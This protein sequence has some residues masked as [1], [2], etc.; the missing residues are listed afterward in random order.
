MYHFFQ[1]ITNTSG[2]SLVGYYGRVIDTTS[3][4]V[5]PIFADDAS[6]PIITVSGVTNTAKTDSVGNMSL[7]VALG[8]YH[9][10]IYGSDATTFLYRVSNVPMMSGPT[11]ATGA[12]GP[13]GSTGAT[14]PSAPGYTTIALGLAGTTEAQAFA[15]PQE[16]SNYLDVYKHVGSYAEF[17]RSDPIGNGFA[18]EQARVIASAIPATPQFLTQPDIHIV[19]NDALKNR[20][21]I[22]PNRSTG[23]TPSRNMFQLVSQISGGTITPGYGGHDF[24]VQLASGATAT[25]F[26]EYPTTADYHVRFQARSTTGAGAQTFK[27]LK[28]GSTVL[29]PYNTSEGAALDMDLTVTGAQSLA[30]YAQGV[31]ADVVGDGLV[32]NLVELAAPQV[33][34]PAS[35]ALVNSTYLSKPGQ[36]AIAH[37]ALIG[38]YTGF[39]K[40][41]ADGSTAVSISAGTFI[42]TIKKNGASSGGFPGPFMAASPTVGNI[43]L[44]EDSSGVMRW[45]AP[46]AVGTLGNASMKFDS[47]GFVTLSVSFDA[48]SSMVYC[49]GVP[50]LATPGPGGSAVS[51]ARYW[52]GGG[53][54][55][56]SSTFNGEMGSLSIWNNERLSDIAMSQAVKVHRAETTLGGALPG[57]RNVFITDGDSITYG[58]LVG[59]D[60]AYPVLAAVN[61]GIICINQAT[62]GSV[63]PA[64]ITRQ[65]MM[66]NRIRACVAQGIRPIVSI[67]IGVN[68]F[69]LISDYQ[70]YVNPLRAAGAYVILCTVT[71]SSAQT[72]ANKA[73]FNA[74]VRGMVCDGIADVAA[75][76]DPTSG[77]ALG[78]QAAAATVALFPDG[79]HPGTYCN[80]LIRDVL[81]P[82]VAAVMQ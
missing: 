64:L 69:P 75:K 72:D 71:G 76:V 8:V 35:G 52:W 45:D 56:S 70:A 81:Q 59:A 74:S 61:L 73:A 42:A 46:G 25:L 37:G 47:K 48:T 54:A 55:Y 21:A 50:I 27:L 32:V 23:V 20:N 77:L 6:T 33:P 17:Q 40:A 22:I 34:V 15:V 18:L 36:M 10:D 53:A 60:A 24:R 67:M 3:G 4:A 13:T 5:V 78:T 68:G 26:S 30:I 1:A 39:V 49:E 2:D 44:G 63:L 12:T 65:A 51:V 19:P 14:G 58:Q 28:N 11:G 9:L 16:S 7:F 31:T 62:P 29:G 41:G 80:G 66:L 57:I 82:V 79:L 38:P 43:T